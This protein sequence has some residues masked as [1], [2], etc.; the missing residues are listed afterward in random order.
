MLAQSTSYTEKKVMVQ[1]SKQ[2]QTHWQE[3]LFRS[4]LNLIFSFLPFEFQV[5]HC[6]LILVDTTWC[7]EIGSLTSLNALEFHAFSDVREP[8]SLHQ[9]VIHR[10]TPF[11][12]GNSGTSVTSSFP[13][14]NLRQDPSLV[15]PSYIFFLFDRSRT[16]MKNDACIVRM[17]SS[18]HLGDYHVAKI[19]NKLT[20]FQKLWAGS[21]QISDSNCLHFLCSNL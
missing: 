19:K 4:R 12:L 6:I 17:R 8:I 20:E 14:T 11:Q 3:I 21:C 1:F 2:D 16:N 7:S 18:D 13:S 9:A 5:F 15:V 10:I